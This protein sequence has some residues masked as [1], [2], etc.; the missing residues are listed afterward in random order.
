LEL[1]KE[2]KGNDIYFL[3][4]IGEKILVNDN[5]SGVLV[6]D[7]ELNLLQ[8]IKFMDGFL[9][10][11]SVKK[12]NEILFI[13]PENGSLVYL[14]LTDYQHKMISLDGWEEWIFSPLFEWQED[15]II[16]SDYKGR[17]AMVDLG[18]ENISEMAPSGKESI[19][20]QQQK[21][22]GFSVE[23]MF[24]EERKA[25]VENKDGDLEVVDYADGLCSLISLP[26]GDFYD[27]EMQGVSVTEI[28]E[29]C[30]LETNLENNECQEYLPEDGYCFLRG[31][32]MMA[33]Q[34]AFLFL[35]S[36]DKADAQRTMIERHPV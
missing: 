16:L 28:S 14:S 30:I 10:E 7:R 35:L 13:C 20:K 36:T 19:L 34:Q 32:Y 33:G 26:K 6:Y 9:I 12:Q 31:K 24:Q 23:K 22:S 8:T 27:Y 5:Y 11:F 3:E 4:I 1:K 21:L 2:L 18:Q 25:V 15:H 17:L 29:D